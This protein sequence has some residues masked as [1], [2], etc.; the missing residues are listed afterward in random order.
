MKN[1]LSTLL[2][3]TILALTATAAD[4]TVDEVVAKVKASYA[5]ATSLT[6]DVR[7]VTASGML[8]Q[9]RVVRGTLRMLLPEMFRID[10]VSPYEQSLIC[11]GETVWIYT[12][13]NEQVVV[14]S[15]TDYQEREMLGNLIG[16][17]ERDYTYEDAG[18]A[19]VDGRPTMVL[20]MVA[21]SDEVAY[22]GGRLWVDTER[23]LPAEVELTDDIGNTISYRL[24]NI[25]L[26]QSL[27][28]S[29]FSFTPP[30]GV[31]VIEY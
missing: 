8:G 29:I 9:R 25:K 3:L 14:S 31:E 20:K 2:L 7:R 28:K 22:P 5:N 27:S 26:N 24:S 16:Y 23:W 18:R 4:Y 13:Q 10:Y 21:R 19:E 17:F 12:P 6:C 11:N 30:E 15:V 1:L